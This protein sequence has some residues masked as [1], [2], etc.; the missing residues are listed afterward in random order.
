MR[1][2]WKRARLTVDA[3][4][5]PLCSYDNDLTGLAQQFRACAS[6]AALAFMEDS[7]FVAHNVNF[8]YGFLAQEFN[9]IDRRFRFP[10]FCTCAGMRRGMFER[11]LI[12]SAQAAQTVRAMAWEVA[13]G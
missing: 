9:K 13:A 5:L 8:D 11:D 7:I 12:E 1:F 3:F 4:E 10:K 2:S 6:P